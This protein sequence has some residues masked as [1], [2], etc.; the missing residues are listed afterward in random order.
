MVLEERTKKCCV[1]CS[2]PRQVRGKRFGINKPC[3]GR[4]ITREFETT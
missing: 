2:D 4:E 3:E 1:L